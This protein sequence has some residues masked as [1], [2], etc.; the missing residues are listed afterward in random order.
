[1]IRED[2]I[3]WICGGEVPLDYEDGAPN[4]P[5]RDHIV[6]RSQFKGKIDELK[7]EFFENNIKLAHRFCNSERQSR[8]VQ[9][10]DAETYQW[11]L[12]VAQ[13]VWEQK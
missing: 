6:P 7:Q 12:L 2:F 3:C 9:E 1:M 4:A 5:S 10:G 11:K 8:D 13:T